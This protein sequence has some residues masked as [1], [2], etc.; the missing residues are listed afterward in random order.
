MLLMLLS[1]DH[2]NIDYFVSKVRFII[3]THIP[4]THII[5]KAQ[6][7][8]KVALVVVEMENKRQEMVSGG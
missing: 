3:I 1:F 5:L 4:R 6:N 2:C 8:G 7:S